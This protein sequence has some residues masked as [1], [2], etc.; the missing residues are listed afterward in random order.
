[1]QYF[2]AKVAA[3]E[4]AIEELREEL[5]K[6][7]RNSSK[8]PS[9]DPPG[10]PRRVGKKPSGRKRGG[11]VGHKGHSRKLF[12]SGEC[13][14]VEDHRPKECQKCGKELKG[15]DPDPYRHQVVELPPVKPTVEEHRLHALRCGA[16]GTMTRAK[17][18]DYVDGVGYGPRLTAIVGYMAIQFGA[19]L[20]KTAGAMSDLF[21][22]GMAHSTVEL[23][24]LEQ[25]V[26]VAVAVE[27]AAEYVRGQ[28][29]VNA[30]ETG[31]SQGNGD[32][33]NPEKRKAWMWVMATRLVV[34]FRITLS[35]SAA[36]A[37]AL[38]GPNF[39]GY[40][41][42]DRYAGY[43]WI[44]LMNRQLCWA[45][46]LRT[47]VL[48][49]QRNGTGGRIGERLLEEGKQLFDWW[50]R[51]KQGT[52]SR[53]T[54]R[55]RVIP[56]R[57]RVRALLEEGA[58]YEPGKGDR[59]GRAKTARTCKNLLKM[60]PA[61]WLFVRVEGVEP[62]NN[63]GERDLRWAV[64]LRRLMQGTQSQYGSEFIARMLT[65]LLT[66]RKQDRNV[67]DFLTQAIAARRTGATA[68]SLLP[69]S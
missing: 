23:M 62:T 2:V 29:V 6:N 60:E 55:R 44:S 42:S 11:Q 38:L 33:N 56:L 21:G 63:E 28:P 27:A 69:A 5:D 24:R 30:D 40:L 39:A 46:L 19:S 43:G 41:V 3:L 45:H 4:A 1:M 22:V 52:L 64:I 31:H 50:D 16:C 32:G 51:L 58:N 25:S 18:P 20:R 66:L 54:F 10:A 48:F 12:P 26:A 53:R 17:L 59:S 7:S 14:L 49:S 35:R 37:K 61:L 36:E 15:D 34:V 9:Q 8:P 65:V 57:K 68:P 47:F 67:L 13:D